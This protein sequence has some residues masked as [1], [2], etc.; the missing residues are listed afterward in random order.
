M[1]LASVGVPSELAGG[2]ADTLGDL[3]DSG[4]A[5][6]PPAPQL[7]QIKAAV[8]DVVN[9]ASAK[10]SASV[11]TETLTWLTS[12]RELVADRKAAGGTVSD[13]KAK[14]FEAALQTALTP[15]SRDSFVDTL[16]YVRDNPEVAQYI[17]PSFIAAIAVFVQLKRIDLGREYL[18]ERARDPQFVFPPSE[19]TNFISAVNAYA[20]GLEKAAKVFGVSSRVVGEREACGRLLRLA[21]RRPCRR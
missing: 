20:R 14:Q 2:M 3:V 1:G 17:I 7:D 10:Q 6:P 13:G 21:R 9:E 16:A 4:M 5:A 8:K 12:F 19:I 15:T 18:P 11:F